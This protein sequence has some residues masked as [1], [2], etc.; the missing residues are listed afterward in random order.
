MHVFLDLP[1]ALTDAEIIAML[2]GASQT[3]QL[4]RD[5]YALDVGGVTSG[6]HVITTVTFEI[7]GNVNVQ[8]FPG[9]FTSTAF[10]LGLGD[11]DFDGDVDPD[12]ITIFES[13]YRSDQAEF[14]PAGDFNGDGLINV[15]DLPLFYEL[16]VTTGNVGAT[17]TAFDQ[18]V[19][20]YAPV[21]YGDAPNSF[22]TLQID[23]GAHHIVM[24]GPFLGTS[25]DTDPNGQPTADADGDDTDE[26]DDENG[27]TA[28]STFVAGQNATVTIDASDSGFIDAWIDFND[29]GVFDH[30]AEHIN[31]AASIAV[32]HRAPMC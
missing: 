1:A 9:Y 30:P 32:T 24:V 29:N 26:T 5:L 22:G 28:V 7:T 6:N 18:F 12:D 15:E 16:L 2:G 21:D 3:N 8:R 25:V 11:L 19:V 17:F 20:T 23:N 14:N 10:G 4:D 27:I 13:A 31:N